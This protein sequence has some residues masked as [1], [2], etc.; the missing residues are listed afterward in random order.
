MEY[1]DILQNS[2]IE[3]G[4]RANFVRASSPSEIEVV[5]KNGVTKKYNIQRL[6]SQ[7]DAIDRA[8]SENSNLIY[9]AHLDPAGCAVIWND[10]V[11]VAIE[12]VWENGEVMSTAFDN[13][14]SMKDATDMWHL[15]ESTLRK[16][17]A[18]GKL[19]EGVDARKFGKQWILIK[20]SVER[21]YG[22]IE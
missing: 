14:I 19:T 7:Y 13:L 18:S 1:K 11:D 12:D 22:K 9:D 10:Y 15:N 4:A 5:F 6:R 16:A 21:E 2:A 8:F 3:V 17:I 20:S